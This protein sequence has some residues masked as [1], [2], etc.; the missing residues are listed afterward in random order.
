MTDTARLTTALAGRYAIDR[1]LGAGG[2]ATVYLARDLKPENILL[3]EGEAVVADFGIALALREAGGPRLTESGLSLGTP[4]YM[5]PEQATGGR[6]L[7]ARSD[8]YSL[9]AVVYEMLTGEPPHTGPTVQ[10]VIAKL[11]TERPTRIRTVRDT[12]PEGIDSA[13]AK[14][15]AKV[16][17]DRFQDVAEFAG[18][19]A[20]ARAV[21]TP[22][23]PRRRMA[24]AA[25]ILG[26][27]ALAA[28]L[29]LLVRTTG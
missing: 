6:E 8:V 22:S 29:W 27:L 28:T 7:D 20:V 19:L 18:A 3:H 23:W 26:A 25:G 1:E 14:A 9:A 11:L 16:P 13:V 5:S 24:V 12:V 4:Q 10:A 15:L 21:A 17:A 2:M